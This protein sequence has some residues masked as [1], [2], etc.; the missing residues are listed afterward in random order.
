MKQSWTRTVQQRLLAAADSDLLRR[1]LWRCFYEWLAARQPEAF[2]VMNYGFADADQAAEAPAGDALGLRLYD[3]VVGA[4]ELRGQRLLEVG[5]GR[6]GG[7]AHIYRR[8]LPRMACGVDFS[9]R[10]VALARQR[11]AELPGV[12]ILPAE[13]DALPFA[14]DSFDA[15]LNIES[16]HCYP[17]RARFFQEVARVLR[18]GGSF[19]Y[20]DLFPADAVDGIRATLT[21]AGFRIVQ[22]HDITDNVATAMRLDEARRVNLIRDSLP[23]VLHGP[24]RAFAG[25]TESPM[26]KSFVDGRR[27]YLRFLLLAG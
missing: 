22:E 20:A 10:A 9:R 2:A 3:E 21:A 4:T 24:L 19:L 11:T 18:P 1:P 12:G 16:S 15:V 14:N 27:R 26:Y 6:A 5:C 7:L 8:C 25:T 17:S 23:R 13:A